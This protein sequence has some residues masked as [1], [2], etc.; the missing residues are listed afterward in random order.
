M[1]GEES[2]PRRRADA[3]EIP[4]NCRNVGKVV[5][6]QASFPF[7][8]APIFVSRGLKAAR[9]CNMGDNLTAHPSAARWS[10]SPADAGALAQSL[11]CSLNM[12]HTGHLL[13]LCLTRTHQVRKKP[14]GPVP[15]PFAGCWPS[16][17]FGGYHC[18]NQHR[19][20]SDFRVC[21]D[22]DGSASKCG[23]PGSD[24]KPR[25][26]GIAIHHSATLRCGV[27]VGV[28]NPTPRA[29]TFRS[30]QRRSFRLSN[31]NSISATF[32]LRSFQSRWP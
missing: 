21:R 3:T 1:R 18:D 13:K 9:I 14:E 2:S 5:W 6:T 10:G 32:E 30:T 31:S 29:G 26:T 16:V 11:A 17:I 12:P 25:S 27:C 22:P 23:G 8:A 15:D 24:R 19:V 20:R 7:T 4:P 28:E